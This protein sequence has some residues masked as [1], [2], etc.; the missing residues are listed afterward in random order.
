M[1]TAA[2]ILPPRRSA[3]PPGQTQHQLHQQQQHQQQQQQNHH[4]QSICGQLRPSPVGHRL[5][6]TFFLTP[7]ICTHCKS[8]PPDGATSARRSRA[9]FA[10]KTSSRQVRFFGNFGRRVGG[11]IGDKVTSVVLPRSMHHLHVLAKGGL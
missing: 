6:E 11:H 9:M 10:N 8:R 7:V 5:V 1:R 4:H 3:W 2:P